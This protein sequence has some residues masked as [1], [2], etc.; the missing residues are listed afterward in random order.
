MGANGQRKILYDRGERQILLPPNFIEMQT[1]SF[2]W[3]MEE[4]LQEELK[5]FGSVKSYDGRMELQFTGSFK[6][7]SAK[8]EARECQIKEVTYQRPLKVGA[9]LVNKETGEAKAQDVFIGDLPFMTERGTF[10][11]N[12]AERVIVSQLVRSAGVYFRETKKLDKQGRPTYFATVIPDRG[13]WLEIESDA[14]FGVFARINRL[15]KIPIVTVLCALGC[16]EKD[17]NESLLMDEYRRRA[18]RDSPM[19][20]KEEALVEIYKRLRPGDPITQEG[21]QVYLNNLFFN[22]R[23]YDL[24]RVGRFKMNR[25]LNVKVPE[26]KQTLTK[27]DFLGMVR[28]LVK[29]NLGEGLPDDI[30]HLG[31]RRVRS[32]GE[33]LARQYRLGFSRVER[34]IKEQMVLH[35]NER[36]MPQQLI[37]IRPLVAIIK[38]FF[39]SSQLSQ[40]MD[41]TNPL[42]ELTHKRR[43]SALGPGGLTRER[44]GFEV[45]DIHPSHYGRICP[46]ETPE[47]PNAGLISSLATFGRVN[48]FGFIET[49]YQRVEKGILTGKVE[50]LTADI[51]DFKK[52][53]PCDVK[54][55]GKGKIQGDWIPVRYRREFI[56]AKPNEVDYMGVAPEQIVGVTT[57]LI[58]FLEHNDANRALMGANM[59]RQ[60]VPLLRPQAPL[61]GTGLERKVAEDSLLMVTSKHPGTVKRVTAEEVVVEGDGNRE[62]YSL[63]KFAR[64][65]QNTLVHQRPIV[66]RGQ[67]VKKN[68]VLADGATTDGGELA[69]GSNVLVGLMPWEGYN[70]EDAILLSERLVKDDVF[71]SVHIERYEME[72]RATKLGMEEIT[73]EIPNVS[74][75]MLKDLDDRGVILAGAEVGPGDILVG[76]VTPKGETE[77]PA[78]EKLLRAIFGDKARDMR[79]TSLRVPSGERGKVVA[80]REFAREQG[81]ELP[82]GVHKLFRVYVAQIRKVSTG[83]KLAGRHGNKG[84]V[85]RIL[86]VEDMPYLPDGTPLDIVLNPL[87]V[88]SRMNIGQIF[89]MLLGHAAAT[90]GEHYQ[91]PPF[92]EWFKDEASVILIQEQLQKAKESGKSWINV[93]GKVRLRDGRTGEYF[94]HPVAVGS[95]YI[96]KL[97]HLVDDKMHARSTGPYSLITQQPLGGKAQFGGQRFGE[98]EVWALEAYG[99]AYTLQELLTVKSDDVEGRAKVYESII[100][101]RPM[102]K[103]GVPESFKVLLKE[104]RSLSLDVRMTDKEG[105][106][107]NIYEEEAEPKSFFARIPTPKKGFSRR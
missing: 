92:D 46:I 52:I 44:A 85:S 98:M 5:S 35:A 88:P 57:A 24:S 62:T 86:P 9:R 53:A 105:K 60:A 93:D 97:I 67:K 96:M 79:D 34:L 41:Q 49:P 99:A 56:F 6:L 61:V 30:D 33:L 4:G 102:G 55:D 63:V 2:K 10:I 47:G 29:M 103:P 1:G 77:L 16:T 8:Y 90:L 26:E 76:K 87:S 43:L 40:F 45:R 54:A 23:R 51:E 39:G 7:G 106:E 74:E 70:Y 81:D 58:P 48:Q 71:T 104:L 18:F 59:Q 19:K 42:A 89:E 100:K 13:A 95:M 83:D 94:D 64:S 36:V 80:V 107:V 32:V 15:R 27:E 20:P 11:I 84:V 65:N 37:N 82:P 21:A 12:G 3:F 28:E 22:A 68:Q 14:T 31:N 38:E 69:L 91:V 101:G 78:E 25:R 72:V 73:R 50:Y 75:E 17:I 66:R